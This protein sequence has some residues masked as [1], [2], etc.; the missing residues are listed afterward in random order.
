M[1][2]AGVHKLILSSYSGL[3]A[4]VQPHQ[5]Q[6]TVVNYLSLNPKFMIII[7][8]LAG[9]LVVSFWRWRGSLALQGSLHFGHT[10]DG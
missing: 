9:I 5:I 4:A 2:F 3:V 1:L 6:F 10:G 7:A 8:L